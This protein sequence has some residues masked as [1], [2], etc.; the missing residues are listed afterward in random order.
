[1]IV[2]TW[3]SYTPENSYVAGPVAD[4][5]GRFGPLSAT[6]SVVPARSA[7][8]NSS[9]VFTG[10]SLPSRATAPS[11]ITSEVRVDPSAIFSLIAP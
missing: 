2:R 10:V 8:T 9:H 3:P 4:G 7:A 5:S 11:V 1:M 6:T